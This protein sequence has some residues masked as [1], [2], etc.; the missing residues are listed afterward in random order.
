MMLLR[1]RALCPHCGSRIPRQGALANPIQCL[2]CGMLARQ[3]RWWNLLGSV[4]VV[5]VGVCVILPVT[6]G[7]GY[8]VLG[9]P[10]TTIGIVVG[11]VSTMALA[12][13]L[14]PYV[15]RYDA[16]ALPSSLGNCYRCGYDLRESHG[17]T[18]PECGAPILRPG[19]EKK[20]VGGA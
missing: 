13:W 15:T 12:W 5:V 16:A 2:N 4:G 18:C 7:V 3:H 14:F 11:A 8:L 20:E 19:K 17:A 9:R 6:G 10:G 1:Y